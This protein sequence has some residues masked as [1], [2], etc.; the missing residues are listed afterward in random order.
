ME[1]AV[2][3]IAI[4]SVLGGIMIALILTMARLRLYLISGLLVTVPAISLYTFWWIGH[5]HGAAA[6]RTAIHAALWGAFPWILYLLV[7]YALARRV[8]TWTAL[9]CGVA[10]Y[11]VANTAVYFLLLRGRI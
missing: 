2:R 11:L 7:A 8:P 4:K 5:Q 9:L 1:S 10:A 3:D 6:M